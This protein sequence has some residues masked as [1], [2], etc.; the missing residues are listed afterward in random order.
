MLVVAMMTPLQVPLKKGMHC[1][2]R[3]SAFA[4]VPFFP[5]PPPLPVFFGSTVFDSSLAGLRGLVLR[6][7]PLLLALGVIAYA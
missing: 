5:F 6:L 2:P 4:S 3:L 7:G 1:L